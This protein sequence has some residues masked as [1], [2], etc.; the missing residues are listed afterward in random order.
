MNEKE[1]CA[2][3]SLQRIYHISESSFDRRNFIKSL[4][5]TILTCTASSVL[6]D[7]TLKKIRIG[8]QKRGPLLVAK[9]MSSLEKRFNSDNVS[10]SWFEF[11]SGPPL[12]EAL[13]AGA[14]DYGFTGDSP[15]IFAQAA[16]AKILYV[17]ANPTHGRSQTIIVQKNSSITLVSELKGKK[18]GVVKGSSGHNLLI[19]SL[20]AAN[21]SLADITPVY[22]SPV[23]AYEAFIRGSIDAWSIWDPYYAIAEV[24]MKARSLP[25][26]RQNILINNFYIANRDFASKYPQALTN[27]NEEVQSATD[28]AV[29]H[30]D[31]TSKMLA[32]ASGVDIIAEKL[33]VDRAEFTFSKLT[34]EIL[35]EQQKVADRYS[36]LNLI[37]N[38]MNI[39]EIVWEKARL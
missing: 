7:E 22:L 30:L 5:A 36:S 39:R 27:I 12:L 15:P 2:L 18:V 32:Q 19:E 11:I 3:L 28:W 6:A 24:E 38:R 31:E 4:S 16:H 9:T 14:I 37:P 10:V 1:S 21:L 25:I 13:N 17:A 26:D 8:Y 29:K 35:D 34:Q 33:S 20:E 23:D